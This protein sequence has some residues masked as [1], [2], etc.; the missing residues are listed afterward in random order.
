VS[1]AVNNH[2]TIEVMVKSVTNEA[3]GI[4]AWEFRR[5]DNALLPAFTA[6]S[7]ITLHLANGLIRNY[8]LCNSPKERHRYVVAVNKDAN[9]TGGSKYIHDTLKPGDTLRISA[10]HNNFPLNEKARHSVLIAGGIGITPM[11][12]MIQ[13]LE[14]LGHSWE[15]HYSARTR[16]MCAFK[17]ALEAIEQLKP[18]RVLLNFDQEPDGKMTD[19]KS[20]ISNAPADADL[21]CC[22]PN[23]MLKAFEQSAKEVGRPDAHIHVEYF[24][25]KEEAAVDGNFT[26]FLQ[27][28]NLSFDIPPGKTILDTLLDDNIDVPYSCMQG[29]CGACQTKVLEGIPDH[30]DAV[31]TDE[32]RASNTTMM[33]CC[34]GSKSP[35]LVLDL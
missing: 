15:L 18:G 33:I 9:S 27:K 1:G 22:G 28:S 6:G 34:S 17:E 10:P 8:S 24:T 23:P 29:V 3:T 21:Y 30:R 12:C 11:F 7:H 14:E 35:K 25:A 26:V 20:V 5:P 16:Q 4:N 19:L 13:R 32:E 2:D 31:L